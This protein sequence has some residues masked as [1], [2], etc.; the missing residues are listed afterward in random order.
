MENIL[1]IFIC[2][3]LGL[4]LQKLKDLPTYSYKTLNLFVTHVSLPALGLY[5]IPKIEINLQLLYPLSI[6][7]LGFLFA[8]VFFYVLG[9][10]MGWS[11]KLIGCLTLTAGLGNTTFIGLPV[12]QALYGD[13]G[14]KIGLVVD[15]PG[16]FVV[17]STLG[18]IIGVF[19]SKEESNIKGILFKVFQFP[20]F[21]IFIFASFL[22]VLH[23]DFPL[24]V[25]TA[26]QKLGATVTP[27]A[28]V[29]VGMQLKIDLRSKHWG[30]LILG[31]LFKLIITPTIFYILY[32]KIGHQNTMQINVSIMQAAMAPMIM[33][34]IIATNYG[35]KPKLSNMMV[36][37]GIPLSFITLTI[38]YFILKFY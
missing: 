17:M 30:F 31:L 19:F 14:M 34:A 7:W 26:F 25:Q 13:E 33:G 32:K 9:K 10:K 1:S 23:L 35:L 38:W 37:I 4:F 36:G 8:F 20:P 22:N 5:Y 3:L 2:L 29:S 27:I 12:I 15:Q 18:V 6:A 16:T 21:I 24:V 28:L 11:N